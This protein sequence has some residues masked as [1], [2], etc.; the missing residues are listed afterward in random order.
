MI[1]Q[2]LQKEQGGYPAS[3]LNSVEAS[4][5]NRI[6]GF[7]NLSQCPGMGDVGFDA[8]AQPNGGGCKMSQIH[9]K[10]LIKQLFGRMRIVIM[11]GRP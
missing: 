10:G 7:R 9:T 1:Q 5:C 2:D 4:A 11:S 3:S 6:R 8:S